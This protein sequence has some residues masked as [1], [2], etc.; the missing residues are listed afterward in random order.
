M[1]AIDIL[2]ITSVVPE[3]TVS[4][5]EIIHEANGH[6]STDVHSMLASM[7]IDQRYFVVEDYP[8]Y[9]SGKIPRRLIENINDLAVK[10]IYK[11]ANSIKKEVNICLFITVTNTAMRPLRSMAYQIIAKVDPTILSR[12]VSVINMQNQGYSS[13]VKAIE[14]AQ[15]FLT[16]NPR[17]QALIRVAET[18]TAMSPPT[19]IEKT[20]AFSEIRSIV[21]GE[22]KEA[23]T[24]RLNKL[25]N[26]HLLGDGAVSMLLQL[27]EDKQNFECVHLTNQSCKDT[28]ILHMDEGG[29]FKPLY[30]G[31]PQYYLS[32]I[33]PAR[34]L[35][36]SKRLFQKLC[37]GSEGNYIDNIDFFLIHTGSKKIIDGVRHAFSLEENEKVSHSYSIIKNFGNLSSCSIGFMLDE[38][39]NIHKKT[40]NFFLISFGVGFS[41][42]IAKWQLRGV[43]EN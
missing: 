26:S 23:A 42:S 25:I 24:L 38:A 40:G 32:K 7:E 1:K 35:F 4:S 11:C 3:Q 30:E 18:H 17:K 39:L 16:T 43:V 12:E 14:V 22:E 20:I 19:L 33:V 15:S 37:G 31:F 34:G 27:G 36:Y 8:R 13:L 41:G 6:L 5:Q 9:L 21:E 10:S 28:E 29:S 2:S